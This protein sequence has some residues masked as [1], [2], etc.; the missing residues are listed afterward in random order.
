MEAGDILNGG[1]DDRLVTQ[2]RVGERDVVRKRYL[3]ADAAGVFQS[4]TD[5]WRSSFGRDRGPNPGLPE[6]LRLHD[7]IGGMDM[8]FVDGPML[9]A[10]GDVGSLPD[11]LRETATLLAD[12]HDSDVVVPR[13]RNATR[14]VASLGRKFSDERP[15]VLAALSNV[16]DRLDEH[17][18]VSHGDFSP[19]NVV[20]AAEGP[21]LIDFDRL[22]MA[23]AGRDVQYL[24]SWCWVTEVVSHATD[25]D[26]AW[27]LGERFEAAYVVCRPH[28]EDE[29]AASR[30]FH[31][32]SGLVRIAMSWSSL[33]DD[34]V[35]R[36]TVLDE[37]V[38][39]LDGCEAAR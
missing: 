25:H 24:A 10:R 9:G 39:Q 27:T 17:L 29:L 20:L 35:A 1:H 30:A 15:E 8:A 28:A 36:G 31:R 6:P 21:T 5:L 19:R 22:Q 18:V 16:A 23:G 38:R 13:R 11:R 4:M 3:R 12:L 37:A 32:A 7:D 34:A 2:V 14:L 26:A 33:R